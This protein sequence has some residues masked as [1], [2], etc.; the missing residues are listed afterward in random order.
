MK[1]ILG[2]DTS[3]DDTSFGL[4]KV[5]K[6]EITIL[7]NIRITNTTTYEKF[8][9]IV[10]EVVARHHF[11]NLSNALNEALKTEKKTYT[12]E[13]IH[14]IGVTAGPGLISSLI[15][16]YYFAYSLSRLYNKIFVPIH[17]M[18]GHLFAVNPVKD[19]LIIMLSGGHSCVY[20]MKNIFQYN[21][22]IDTLDDAMGE[23]FDKVGRCLELSFPAGPKIEELAKKHT[24][25]IKL[26]I[27]M[28]GKLQFSFSGLKT[29]FINLIEKLNKE[30]NNIMNEEIKANVSWALQNVMA[31]TL[32]EKIN[33][34]LKSTEL[35]IGNMVFCGGVISNTYI[36]NYVQEQYKDHEINLIF[37][38]K[39]LCVDNGVMIARAAYYRYKYKKI[40]LLEPFSRKKLCE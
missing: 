31:R 8:G 26:K 28:E 33:I 17:H 29:A 2:I 22:I 30:N 15:V 19:S 32:C 40:E 37:P 27:P 38:P 13:E 20:Y 39:E 23:V 21:L 36:R 6:N 10:P 3:C 34:I 16:G 1:L 24:K 12:L 14:I 5:E 7:S 25:E 11:E 18:E 4:I 9:G 35:V